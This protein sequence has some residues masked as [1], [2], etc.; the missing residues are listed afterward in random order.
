MTCD[1][2]IFG[3]TYRAIVSQVKVHEQIPFSIGRSQWTCKEFA[4]SFHESFLIRDTF[5]LNYLTLLKRLNWSLF[6]FPEKQSINPSFEF[7]S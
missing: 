4:N 6:S 5:D 2:L 3:N 1:T 7:E